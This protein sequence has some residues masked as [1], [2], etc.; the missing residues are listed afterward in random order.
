MKGKKIAKRLLSMSSVELME[1]DSYEDKYRK[2]NREKSMTSHKARFWC[3]CCDAHLVG[4]VGKCPNC[5]TIQNPK[6]RK[7]M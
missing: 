5:G 7:K 2:T 1:Y 6:K 3:E 4:E